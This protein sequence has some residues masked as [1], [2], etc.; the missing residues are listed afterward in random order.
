MLCNATLVAYW[1]VPVSK[2][3]W[4]SGIISDTINVPAINWYK[5]QSIDTCNYCMQSWRRKSGGKT[6]EPLCI[7]HMCSV[8]LSPSGGDVW[9]V[10]ESR[11]GSLIPHLSAC[12]K[13]MGDSGNWHQRLRHAAA[14]LSPEM[15]HLRPSSHA[16][17]QAPD[18][19]KVT[20]ED[21]CQSTCSWG[22][23]APVLK[24][25]W[26]YVISFCTIVLLNVTPSAAVCCIVFQEFT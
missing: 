21:F 10:V 2:P 11:T 20:K 9:F 17:C 24:W 13:Q 25:K 12:P 23:C 18:D 8:S 19:V 26:T 1:F 16:V 22:Q 4:S 6:E 5:R 7:S 15:Q 3:L 14:A